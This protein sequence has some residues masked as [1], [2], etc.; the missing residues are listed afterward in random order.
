M[1]YIEGD[2]FPAGDNC[3]NW[4]VEVSIELMDASVILLFSFT[5]H[6]F[7]VVQDVL[8]SSVQVRFITTTV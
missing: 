4:W 3:N 5:A 1:A 6:V 2:V 8:P 7:L